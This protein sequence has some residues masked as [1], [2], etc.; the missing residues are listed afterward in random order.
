M[1]LHIKNMVSDRCKMLVKSEIEKLELHYILV[2][3]GEVEIMETPSPE[4]LTQLNDELLKSGLSIISDHNSILIEQI[5]NTI[6]ELVHYTEKQI[7][8]NFSVYLSEKL[9][10]DYTYL[11]NIFSENQGISIEHFLLTHRIEKVKE[12]L[13]YDEMNISEIAYTLHFSSTAHL[14]NQF[15]KLT[16]LTPSTYKRLKLNRRTSL[17][18]V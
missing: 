13:L 8:I 14:S 12:L 18:N 17:E 10:Y 5:K 16:G 1:K 2:A 6:I 3:L 7:K 11:A 9:K 15:K 4:Q